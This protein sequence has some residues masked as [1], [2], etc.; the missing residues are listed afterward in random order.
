VKISGIDYTLRFNPSVTTA[1]ALA[2]Q[3]CIEQGGRFGITVETLDNCIAPMTSYLQ[4]EVNQ[5][6]VTNPPITSASGAIDVNITLLLYFVWVND[7]L[8]F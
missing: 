1:G 8:N 2:K 6:S 5:R 3:F 7:T 4:K